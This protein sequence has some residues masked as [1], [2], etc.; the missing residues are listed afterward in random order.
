MRCPSTWQNDFQEALIENPARGADLLPPEFFA[1][2]FAELLNR[3]PNNI[4]SVPPVHLP[5]G[6]RGVRGDLLET[7][8]DDDDGDLV[9]V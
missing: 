5:T 9:P 1:A 7:A 3:A 4:R 8:D 2:F 6:D